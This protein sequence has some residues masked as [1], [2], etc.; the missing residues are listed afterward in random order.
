MVGEVLPRLTN[1]VFHVTSYD[2]YLAI[3]ESGFISHNV[4]DR[5]GHVYGQ[6]L[7]CIGRNLRAVCLFDLRHNDLGSL[8][9]EL[10]CY[11]L[12]TVPQFG[13]RVV[14]LFVSKAQVGQLVQWDSLPT[15]QKLAGQFI[16]K[17]ECWYPGDLPTSHISDVLVV[18]VDRPS[19]RGPEQ[20]LAEFTEET[21]W[22]PGEPMPNGLVG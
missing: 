17:I 10:S 8:G 16:P 20:M 19:H 11:N 6:S 3:I 21:S 13:S 14:F 5:H 18:D 12:P 7:G 15:E 1:R 9:Y 22:R 4:D 2:R